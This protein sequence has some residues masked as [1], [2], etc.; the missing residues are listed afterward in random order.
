MY[1][2]IDISNVIKQSTCHLNKLNATYFLQ[3]SLP[4]LNPA[5]LV[6][7]KFHLKNRVDKWCKAHCNP[8]DNE[9]L[10]VM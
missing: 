1:G 9:Q 2:G 10:K 3:V 8:Y 5:L 4:L 6:V 7:D